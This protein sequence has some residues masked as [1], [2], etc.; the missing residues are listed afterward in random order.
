MKIETQKALESMFEKLSQIKPLTLG[1]FIEKTK[2]LPLDTQIV[3]ADSN[4]G[5]YLNINEIM[6][7]DESNFA[8]TFYTKDDFDPRQF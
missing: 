5:W 8:I 7:P 6:L 4:A 3:V 1:D 2:G